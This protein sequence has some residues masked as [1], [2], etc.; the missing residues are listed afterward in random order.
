MRSRSIS[1]QLLLSMGV[2]VL[3]FCIVVA[4]Y[5][6]CVVAQDGSGG[7]DGLWMPFFLFPPM[8]WFASFLA[9]LLLRRFADRTHT[10]IKTFL[11]TPGLYAAGV[12]IAVAAAG[13]GLYI[14]ILFA[15]SWL[16]T[17]LGFRLRRAVRDVHGPPECV[18][19]SY[20]LTGNTSG[21][22]PECG[23]PLSEEAQSKL[24]DKEPTPTPDPSKESL[25]WATHRGTE[26]VDRD[27]GQVG[28]PGMY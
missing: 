8:L 24:R 9:W 12:L 23:T 11:A 6:L 18:K 1:G 21:T 25:G 2:G 13:I 14:P 17:F 28:E 16:F 3:A 10:W 5:L 19:C 26:G 20:N 4:A 15:P 22:C 27:A 7:C